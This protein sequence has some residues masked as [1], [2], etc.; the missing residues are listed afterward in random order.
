MLIFPVVVAGSLAALTG[1]ALF[2]LL[3]LKSQRPD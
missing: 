3:V 2:L 1:M